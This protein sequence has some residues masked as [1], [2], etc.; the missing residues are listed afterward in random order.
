MLFEKDVH[1]NP[2]PCTSFLIYILCFTEK[3]GY[4]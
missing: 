3:D 1:V 4:M 2:K